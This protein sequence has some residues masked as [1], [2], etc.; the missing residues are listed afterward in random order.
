MTDAQRS[1]VLIK[2]D[3]VVRGLIGHIIARYEAKGLTVLSLELREVDN[4]LAARHYAE[5]EGKPF[6]PSL[7]EFITSGPVVAMVLEGEKAI[8]AIRLINGATD[9]AAAAPGTIRGDLSLS[10]NFN[11]VHASDSL[12]S[13]DREIS[14]WFP[15]LA[16]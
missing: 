4:A 13:A 6:Y 2:P 16:G 11:L 10:K 12:E 14:L 15:R 3:A 9:S 7:L 5:H 1:L 8:D